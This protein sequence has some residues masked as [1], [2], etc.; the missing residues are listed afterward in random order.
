MAT[1]LAALLRNYAPDGNPC[2]DLLSDGRLFLAPL[3]PCLR[4]PSPITLTVEAPLAV[5]DETISL[6]TTSTTPVILE[7]GRVLFLTSTNTVTVLTETTFDATSSPVT[8]PIEASTVVAAA[9]DTFDFINRL[10][11]LTAEDLSVDYGFDTESSNK[12]RQ[13][14]RKNMRIVGYQPV[15]SGTLFTDL[16]D[17]SVWGD[18]YLVSNGLTGKELFAYLSLAGGEV[19]IIGPAILT[20]FGISNGANS[21][22]KITAELTFND[23]TVTLPAFRQLATADQTSFNAIRNCFGLPSLT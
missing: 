14:L 12:V 5:D 21:L 7:A 20:S 13:G 6:S 15:V 11:L 17:G 22:S 23:E 2:G 8:V 18:Q 19:A 1:N 16:D 3:T 10:E 9:T 4:V